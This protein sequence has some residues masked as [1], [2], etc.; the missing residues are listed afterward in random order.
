VSPRKNG[1]WHDIKEIIFTNPL[2]ISGGLELFCDALNLISDVLVEAKVK[3]TFLQSDDEMYSMPSVEYIEL[4][5]ADWDF[6][7]SL[8]DR[9]D[10]K[11]LMAYAVKEGRVVV[12]PQV[13]EGQRLVVDSL[14]KLNIPFL[15][16]EVTDVK[17]V[18]DAHEQP[19]FLF[20]SNNS[21]SL[22]KVLKQSVLSKKGKSMCER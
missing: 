9:M 3:V 15:A 20:K 13:Y 7:W 1:K 22:A 16:S 4:R 17:D 14:I 8:I 10:A 5:A 19:N 6:E 2:T 18:F 21:E 11:G 12:L